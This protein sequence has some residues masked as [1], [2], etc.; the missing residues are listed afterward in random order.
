M[1]AGVAWFSGFP[2]LPIFN[3][4]P[5]QHLLIVATGGDGQHLAIVSPQDASQIEESLSQ[6]LATVQ[7]RCALESGVNWLHVGP[8]VLAWL[9]AELQ[10]SRRYS[11]ENADPEA[12][13]GDLGALPLP[14]LEPED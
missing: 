12:P 7:V 11:S 2:V 3:A 8:G 6:A 13:P 4:S 9:K 1:I 5:A 14:G 10:S